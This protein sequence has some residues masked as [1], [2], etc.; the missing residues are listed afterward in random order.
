MPAIPGLRSPYTIVTRLC[1]VGRMFDKIRLHARGELPAA[2][3]PSL[4]K[5][6]DRR[7][8]TFIGLDYPTIRDRV[9]AGGTDA[10]LEAWLFSGGRDRSDAD[11]HM[12]NH[13]IS[14]LGW[15]DERSDFLRQRIVEDGFTNRGVETFFDLIEVDEG[16][17]IG[18]PYA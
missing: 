13:F 10:E 17:P 18:G 6:L 12:W 16:R 5:G 14:K 8:W 3:Q 2:Y 15:R 7:V 4:G 11:C 9:L 1:Y